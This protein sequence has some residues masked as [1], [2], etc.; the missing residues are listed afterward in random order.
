MH[1][2]EISLAPGTTVPAG[3]LAQLVDAVVGGDASAVR[4]RLIVPTQV[5]AGEVIVPGKVVGAG[6]PDQTPETEVDLVWVSAGRAP[7][8]DD[9]QPAGVLEMMFASANGLPDQGTVRISG[10]TEVA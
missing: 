4:E 1:D 2:L 9:P 8:P 10:G 3:A 6:G 7:G 5:V